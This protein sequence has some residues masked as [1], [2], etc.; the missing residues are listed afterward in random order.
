MSVTCK[1]CKTYYSDKISDKCLR[2]GTKLPQEKESVT[3][4]DS[5]IFKQLH[6]EIKRLKK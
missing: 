6:D 2:C 3:K 5:S 1:K 4:T